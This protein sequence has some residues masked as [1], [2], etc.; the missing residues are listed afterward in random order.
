MGKLNSKTHLFQLWL[1]VRIRFITSVT[2]VLLDLCLTRRVF[3]LKIH[4]SAV[5]LIPSLI[6]SSLSVLEASLL[7]ALKMKLDFGLL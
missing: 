4:S 5:N 3:K 1:L 7:V 6:C 2:G